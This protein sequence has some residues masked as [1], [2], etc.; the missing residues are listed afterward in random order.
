M[1]VGKADQISGAGAA[2]TVFGY[3]KDFSL[4]EGKHGTWRSLSG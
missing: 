2:E 1:R 3:L 4:T